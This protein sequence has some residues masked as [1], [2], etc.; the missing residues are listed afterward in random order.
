MI[1][2]VKFTILSIIYNL[3]IYARLKSNDTDNQFLFVIVVTY[4]GIITQLVDTSNNSICV[5]SLFNKECCQGKVTALQRSETLR[6]PNKFCDQIK[7]E[8][9]CHR[10]HQR[11]VWFSEIPKDHTASAGTLKLSKEAFI[12]PTAL[13]D[14]AAAHVGLIIFLVNDI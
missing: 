4:P 12:K 11:S 6:V 7:E 8:Q 5:P 3:H 2:N 1:Y 10:W 9:A 14:G 13:I